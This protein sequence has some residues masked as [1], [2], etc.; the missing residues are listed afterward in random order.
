M[1]EIRLDDVAIKKGAVE[2]L[3][4]RR[5]NKRTKD[6]AGGDEKPGEGR[7]VAE[8]VVWIPK[9]GDVGQFAVVRIGSDPNHDDADADEDRFKADGPAQFLDDWPDGPDEENPG[10]RFGDIEPVFVFV[11][12]QSLEGSESH[13]DK[14]RCNASNERCAAQP[15]DKRVHGCL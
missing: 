8:L 9:F 6:D 5:N 10:E 11:A 12:K 3:F 4:Q 7:T 2:H 15:G 13:E 14:K 1:L